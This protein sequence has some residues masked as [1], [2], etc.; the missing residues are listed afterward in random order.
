VIQS[1]GMEYEL[2]PPGDHG[3]N[4]AERAIQTAKKLLVVIMCGVHDTFPMHLWCRLLPQAELTLK[5]LRQ[6]NVTPNVS[7]Y[8]HVHGQHNYM[9]KPFTPMEC[10]IQAHEKPDKRRTWDPHAVDGWNLGTSMEHHRCFK[11]YVKSTRA[12]RVT[13]TVL[14]KHMYITNPTVT[15]EDTVVAASQQLT[16]AIKGTTPRSMSSCSK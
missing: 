12:E 8:A 4:I 9:R 15:P 11:I 1:N 16:Q 3:R 5:V 13:D 14:F 6:S 7:A 10:A 2:V